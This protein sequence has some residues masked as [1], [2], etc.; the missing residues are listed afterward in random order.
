MQLSDDGTK[1]DFI[2]KNTAT[3]TGSEV[4]LVSDETVRKFICYSPP[5]SISQDNFTIGHL[6][7][8]TDKQIASL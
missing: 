5:D 4:R 6:L 3:L 2:K 1:P 7:G 8:A